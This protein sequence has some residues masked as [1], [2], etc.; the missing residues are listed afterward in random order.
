MCDDWRPVLHAPI[1]KPII[2]RLLDGEICGGERD[3]HGMFWR[4]HGDRGEVFPEDW[5][6]MPAASGMFRKLTYEPRKTQGVV[7]GL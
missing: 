2:L 3:E 5:V 1:R 7:D 4:T 6:S